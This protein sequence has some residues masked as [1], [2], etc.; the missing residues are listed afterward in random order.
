MGGELAAFGLDAAQGS[1]KF[2]LHLRQGLLCDGLAAHRALHPCFQA[3]VDV[4]GLLEFHTELVDA[5]LRLGQ[6]VGILALV[7]VCLAAGHLLSHGPNLGIQAF[8][9]GNLR[10]FPL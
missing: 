9:V 10:F 8:R 7:G 3:V 6:R 2:P 4:L 1:S 5:C